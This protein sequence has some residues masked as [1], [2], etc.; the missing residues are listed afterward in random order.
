MKSLIAIFLFLL[1]HG[2]GF[3]QQSVQPLARAHAHND[4]QHDRPFWEAHEHG[5]CSIE[6]DIFRVRDELYVAHDVFGLIKK[7]KL[8]ELY[9]DPLFKVV[10]ENGG[11]VYKDYEAP[12]ILL[13]DIKRD[14]AAALELL[15]K[16]LEDYKE[17]LCCVEDG[18]YQKRAVQ[19]VL[20]GDRP[21]QLIKD[22]ADRMMAID[23]RL[24]D[25]SSDLPPELL[26][27]ISARWGSHFKWRGRGEMPEDQRRKLQEYVAR[28][29]QANRRI[30]FWATPDSVAVWKELVAAEVDLINADG[31]SELKDFLLELESDEQD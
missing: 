28:A 23:G 4:Y 26:P 22:D 16:T 6:V 29:H 15:K 24:S 21:K 11:W 18:V 20:S 8:T 3:S 12:I 19:I 27:L 13:V 30:R 1:I 5:F 2:V 25:L 17:M 31:L 14:G 7:R 9:L 10:Q